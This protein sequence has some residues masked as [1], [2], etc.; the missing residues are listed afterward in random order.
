MT[1]LAVFCLL[2]PPPSHQNRA[3]SPPSQNAR[4]PDPPHAPAELDGIPNT[5]PATRSGVWRKRRHKPVDPIVLQVPQ[6]GSDGGGRDAQEGWARVSDHAGPPE[7][8]VKRVQPQKRPPSPAMS[9]PRRDPRGERWESALSKEASCGC[10]LPT[11]RWLN[12]L[13]LL[14]IS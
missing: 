9:S 6:P 7:T 3:L 12:K 8:G 14:S 4:G 5:A 1:A 11:P 2:A 10:W 13:V